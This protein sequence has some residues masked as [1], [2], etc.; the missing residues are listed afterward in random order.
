MIQEEL[1]K[2]VIVFFEN[3]QKYYGSKTEI[4][5]GI[6]LDNQCFD[7]KLTTWNLFE[8]DLI[9]SAYREN[10][11]KFMI[12]GIG[13]YYEISALNV[14]DFQKLGRNKF[15]F[16]EKYGNSVFRITKLRFH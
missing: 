5:E 1:N 16:I 3:I 14:I 11:K 4:T 7:S 15:Q 2:L 12:E 8:F 6:S 9:R 13:N 10:G